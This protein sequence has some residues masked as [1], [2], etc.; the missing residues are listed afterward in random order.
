[1]RGM[2]RAPLKR[3]G[4]LFTILLITPG[5]SALSKAQQLSREQWGAMP[6]TVSHTGGKWTIA[7]RTNRVTLSEKDLALTIQTGPAQW[8]MMPSKVGDML[9]K[10]KDEQLA[11]RL[12]DAK[13]ISIVPYDAAF[14][15]GVKIALSGWQHKGTQL[16]LELFLTICLEGRNEEV[17]FDV[18]ANE[19]ET[20]LRQLDWPGALDAREIDYTLLSNGRGTLLPRNWPKEYYPIRSI[21]PE[22]KIAASDHSLLQ[23]HVIESWSMS[24]W[25]FQKGN[26]GLMVI[27]ET[28]DDAAYQFSH[29]AGGPTL[30][31]PRWRAQLNRFGYLR[32][33]RMIPIAGNYVDMAQRYRRYTMET[34]LFVSLKEKIART[35]AVGNLIGVPQMRVSILRNLSPES[36]RYDTKDPAKNYSLTTFDERA[37]QLR[38]LKAKGLERVLVFVSG[39]PHLGY[40]RQHPDSLPPPEQAG[41]WEGMKRLVDTCREIGYPVIFHD[42]Y[43]DFYLDAPS[44]NEQFTVHEEDASLPAQQFPGSRFGDSKQ[45]NVPMMRHWDG[46]RQAYLNARFQL[47]HLLKNY[48]LLF[49][50]QIRTQG[51]YIDVIGYVPPDQDFNPEHPTTHTDAMRGQI[52]MLNWARHN[53]GIIATEAGA[54]WTIPYVDIVNSSGG[55]S[56][57]ILV[58]LYNLVYHDAVIVSFSARDEKTLLQGL[59]FG[60]VPE[61]PINQSAVSDKAIT[62]MRQMCA[63]HK[64]VGLLQMTRHEFLDSNYRKERTTFADGTTV[65]VDWDS[66]NYKIEPELR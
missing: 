60:G 9:V 10:W 26:S 34:G 3:I 61:M 22:G 21:T 29:P 5:L 49:D 51:I 15:T 31:G 42:Q 7:D 25:G 52:A 39:W 58:P 66:N 64:R 55:G 56:K 13:R 32:S 16:D 43:R 65:T 14:K 35:P 62:L 48:Q 37:Q 40:D 50:H 54:D 18:V 23:S 2:S 41:G 1:M 4:C 63:L 33:A 17:V 12:A 30:L 46:G 36:D 53:L 59:L 8:T 6:V 24:W 45:E 27:V 47:G 19:R 11:L 57:A 38:E 44:Y 28:P 20:S